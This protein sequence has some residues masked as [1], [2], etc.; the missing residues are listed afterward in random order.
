MFKIYACKSVDFLNLRYPVHFSINWSLNQL[1]LRSS[2]FQLKVE[3]TSKM[4][5]FC[6]ALLCDW[7]TKLT[8]PFQL[9]EKPKLPVTWSVW[10]SHASR[11]L[12]F[13][14][15]NS[16]LFFVIVSYCLAFVALFKKQNCFT[17]V[18]L[19]KHFPCPI[20]NLFLLQVEIYI[21]F[22]LDWCT[23]LRKWFDNKLGYKTHRWCSRKNNF[24]LSKLIPYFISASSLVQPAAILHQISS[25]STWRPLIQILLIHP[26]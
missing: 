23:V 16:H 11:S 18:S 7:P 22:L 3:S 20:K 8:K 13:R 24:F 5:G 25:D 2:Y 10:F 21:E 15:L 4:L 6:W 1:Q 14:A 17:R 19:K 9:D 26:T 12:L